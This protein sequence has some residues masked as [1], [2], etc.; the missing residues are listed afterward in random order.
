MEI[1]FF[2]VVPKHLNSFTLS[3][4]LIS[5]FYQA[6]K[7]SEVRGFHSSFVDDPGLLG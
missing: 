3:K 7:L 5:H 1:L 2:R 6:L 4:D